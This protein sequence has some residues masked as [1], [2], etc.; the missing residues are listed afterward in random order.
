MR[1]LEDLS[2]PEIAAVLAV[3]EPAVK[4]CATCSATLRRTCHEFA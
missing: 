4:G 1:Y 2:V 3:K